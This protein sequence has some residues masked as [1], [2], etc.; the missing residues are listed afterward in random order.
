MKQTFSLKRRRRIYSRLL[1]A[2]CK[3]TTNQRP[4]KICVFCASHFF[5]LPTTR[6]LITTN[7]CFSLK[8][9]CAHFKTHIFFN[10]WIVLL[11]LI[12]LL[13]SPPQSFKTQIKAGCF[14]EKSFASTFWLLFFTLCWGVQPKQQIDQMANLW[15]I[16]FRRQHSPRIDRAKTLG[17]Q[18]GMCFGKKFNAIWR[19]S[20]IAAA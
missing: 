7:I 12:A 2:S 20:E 17:H 13:I 4:S 18:I 3:F 6:K 11:G 9:I 16:G 8:D 1:K 5:A 10:I 14:V 15:S 19:Y